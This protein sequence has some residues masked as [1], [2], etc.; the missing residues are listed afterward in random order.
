MGFHILTDFWGTAGIGITHIVRLEAEAGTHGRRDSGHPHTRRKVESETGVGRGRDTRFVL[1]KAFHHAKFVCGVILHA[2]LKISRH[3]L[4]ERTARTRKDTKRRFDACHPHGTKGHL[5]L[6]RSLHACGERGGSRYGYV[7]GIFQ[8]IGTRLH[9]DTGYGA[10]HL[11]GT[12][13]RRVLERTL[14][15]GNTSLLQALN[16][17]AACIQTACCGL[18]DVGKSLRFNAFRL[19]KILK[20]KLFL[21][22]ICEGLVP[23]ARLD[24]FRGDYRRPVLN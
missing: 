15:V 11:A 18:V 22:A 3:C 2:H 12:E 8:Q 20:I 5:G 1:L 13:F 21:H 10:L 24:F 17:N 9:P 4:R 19:L 16:G 6:D 23:F 14:L 7:V